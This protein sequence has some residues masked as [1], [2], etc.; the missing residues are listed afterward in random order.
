M[1]EI[2]FPAVETK[3]TPM[4]IIKIKHVPCESLSVTFV[5]EVAQIVET[6]Q[7]KWLTLEE[8]ASLEGYSEVDLKI[9]QESMNV[10]IAP[11]GLMSL[12]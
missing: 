10:Y 5:A 7:I 12:E 1:Q 2:L 6:E 4:G 9:L 3:V 8:Y 11:V